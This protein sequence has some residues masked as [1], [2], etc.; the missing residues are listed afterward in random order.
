MAN[1]GRGGDFRPDYA[2]PPGETL[3]EVLNSIGMTQRELATRMGRPLKTINEIIKGK[4][5][6]TAETALQLE[7]VLNVPASFWRNLESD[8]R[9]TLA[10]I[11]QRTKLPTGQWLDSIPVEAMVQRGWIKGHED[12]AQQTEEVLRFFGIASED[13][14]DS[15]T[16]PRAAFKKAKAFDSDPGA[17]AAWLRKGE[18]EAYS[19]SCRVYDRNAFRECLG[20]IRK[21][22]VEPEEVFR[23]ALQRICAEVGVVVAL[24]PELPKSRVCGA[25]RWMSPE[26]ALIELSDRYKTDDHFWFTFYHEAGHVLLHSKK[27]LF[28]DDRALSGEHKEPEVEAQ[29]REANDFAMTSL[30]PL[31]AWKHFI[32]ERDFT[33]RSIRAFAKSIGIAPGIIVGQLQHNRYMRFNSSLNCL[34]RKLGVA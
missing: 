31:R 13:V 33:E 19:R 3:M 12:K 15:L 30:I 6:I 2:I 5:Q 14:W 28:M 1:K 22:T 25:S 18:L 29:E 4:A 17:L 9:E 10:R 20:E 27:D 7:R 23:P 32:S 21:L 26:K 8:Y 16:V 34:K 24:V 11:D